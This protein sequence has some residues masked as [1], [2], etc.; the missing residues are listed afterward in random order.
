MI[1]IAIVEGKI[2]SSM[3]IDDLDEQG[4]RDILIEMKNLNQVIGERIVEFVQSKEYLTFDQSKVI[5]DWVKKG[6]TEKAISSHQFFVDSSYEDAV[7]YVTRVMK[8]KDLYESNGS[9]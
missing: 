2:V 8:N 6:N 9:V 4:L 1:N 3:E 5:T 7:A